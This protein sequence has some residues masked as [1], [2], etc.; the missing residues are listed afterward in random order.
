MKRIL[1]AT[2]AI[3]AVGL[4]QTANAADLPR[5]SSAAAPA[6][7]Y[8]AAPLFTWTGVYAGVNFGYGFGK[9]NGTNGGTFGKA[10]GGLVGATLG[11]NY[12]VGQA[13]FGLEGDYGYDGAKNTNIVPGRGLGI[14]AASA[15][16]KMSDLLTARARLGY[17]VDRAL[18][19]VTG[20]YAGATV[21]TSVVDPTLPATFSSS[22]WRNGYAL[23]GGL[24]YAFTQN[25]SAKAEY[26]Y[27][28][29]G[30][31]TALAAPWTSNVGLHQ[32]LIRGGVNYRF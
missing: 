20:G 23:G 7:I 14:G 2:A 3:A 9:F 15:T 26:L 8:S 24:E 30:S 17:S 18:L 19:F 6:P 29:F 27:T 21:K 16:G 28:S 31:K 4:A 12:Q 1:F 10:D 13:L 22:A 11:Y 5:R 25:I 32:N